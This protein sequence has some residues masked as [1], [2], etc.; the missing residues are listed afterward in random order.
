MITKKFG[1]FFFSTFNAAT[2]ILSEDFVESY[3]GTE[4]FGFEGLSEAVYLRTYSRLI[5]DV[6]KEEWTDTIARVI[7]G[8]FEMQLKHF[9]EQNI[10]YDIDEITQSAEIMFD[11]MF[12]F[13]FLPSGRGLYAMGTNLTKKEIYMALHSCAFVSTKDLKYDPCRPFLFIMDVSMLG[14]GCGFDC[15]GAGQLYIRGPNHSSSSSSSVIVED[16][17]HGWIESVGDLLESYFFGTN[18]IKFDYSLIRPRGTP[19]KTFGGVAPGPDPLRELHENLRD[20]LDRSVN[21]FITSTDIVN[22]ANLIATCV[23]SGGIRRTAEIALGE[24]DDEEFLNLKDYKINPYREMFGWTSNNSIFAQLGMDYSQIVK[25]IVNTGGEPGMAWL[26]N[27]Q[28]YSRMNG[29]IDNVDYRVEGG[30]PCLEQS[31]ESYE[32]C[33]LVE[34]FPSK[35]ETLEEYLETLEYAHLYGK[36]A[37]LGKMHW[38]ETEEVVRRNYRMGISMSGIVEFL[39][40]RGI[41]TFKEWCNEGY[42]N[43]RIFD[44]QLSKE[45]NVNESIKLTS[46]KPSGT[47]S[48]VA[49][50]T[51]GCHF[52]ENKYYIRRLRIE[53]ND[54]ILESLKKAGYQIEPD[55]KTKN[56]LVVEFPIALPKG[57]RGNGEV[58]MWEKFSLA[59]FMQENWADNQVSCTITFRPEEAKDIKQ[60]L[61]YFQYKLKGISLLPYDTTF[62]E[63]LPIEKITEEE[64]IEKSKKIN[65]VNFNKVIKDADD[66]P[67]YCSNDTCI[68]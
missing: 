17:R 22:I 7:E 16:S 3:R 24:H 50:T 5:D 32:T 9:T 33:C 29:I 15:K 34:T 23:I 59:A 63:Q 1:R 21:K 48:L 52:P 45:W 65:K 40:S 6:K 54:P 8:T 42:D 43:L 38:D 46:V 66:I 58:S 20:V 14:V 18:P 49:G 27:M 56:V 26:S 13:K 35:N 44:K 12:N 2:P 68:L 55:K 36:T 64:Y 4:K 39:E 10:L 41:D 51:A 30:N 47:L 61:D 37:L 19:L 60:A 57:I 25:S 11:K 62:Y 28:D 67:K 31:L 53:E